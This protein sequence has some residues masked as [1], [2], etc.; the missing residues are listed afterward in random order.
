[1]LN[2]FLTTA[3]VL[4]CFLSGS[5][6]LLQPFMK[7]AY[8]FSR[9]S[10]HCLVFTV[11]ATS[12]SS[13]NADPYILGPG[14]T[15]NINVFQEPELSVESKISTNGTIDYPLIG[16]L[17]IKGLT[18]SDTETLLDKKLRGDY[19]I[20]PQ[21]SVSIITHRPFFVTGAVRS[22][23]G[24]EYQPGMS[25]RQAVAVAGDFTDRASRSKI[26]L[27]REGS[28]EAGKKVK[29]SEQVGPGDTITVK[30]SLF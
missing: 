27:I 17:K 10:L 22:P 25:V 11:L 4:G 16:E 21:I 8:S 2:L 9:A 29:L 24:Y 14:D 26:F 18:L 19:L 7:L 15:I 20:D 30:E 1:M 3:T 5:I 28:N 6:N 13:A 12:F 23:G